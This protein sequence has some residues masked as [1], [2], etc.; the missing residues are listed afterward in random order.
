MPKVK[1]VSR[2]LREMFRETCDSLE[3]LWANRRTVEPFSEAGLA[4]Q[5]SQV[6]YLMLKTI[7]R[8]EDEDYD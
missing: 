8:T 4:I 5:Q 6:L 3:N 1:P 7:L 2:E